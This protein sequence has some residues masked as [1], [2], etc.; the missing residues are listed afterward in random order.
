MSWQ[1]K[2][3]TPPPGY[4]YGP[5]YHPSRENIVRGIVYIAQG[6]PRS[7]AH[8]ALWAIADMPVPPLVRGHDHLPTQGPLLLAVNHYERPGLWMVW[9]ALLVSH[10]VQERTGGDTHWIAIE[11]WES[12]SFKGIPIPPE[13]TRAVFARTFA[14]YGIIAMPSPHAPV[15]AR[16]AAMRA[17][18]RDIKAGKIIGLMP[19]G[20]VGP[21]PELLEAREGVGTFVL[22]LAGA[23]GRVVPTGIYEEGQHLV[24]HFGP[25]VDLALPESLPK[26]ERDAW[27]RRRL[28]LA[29]RDLLP[30]PLWGVYAGR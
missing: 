20:D 2:S 18:A 17:A 4:Q 19:E 10:L 1:P 29:I 23:G 12:F 22:L 6:R 11:E 14:T 9:P 8:D 21:T 28:M 5:A 25:P 26:S 24:V 13:A 16:A 27:A 7:L 15:A 3:A 30:R